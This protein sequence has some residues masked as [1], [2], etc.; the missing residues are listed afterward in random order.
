MTDRSVTSLWFR[1]GRLC[2]APEGASS[3]S[4]IGTGPWD[5]D[6]EKAAK[7]VEKA[8][9]AE[10]KKRKREEKEEEEEGEEEEEL[11]DSHYEDWCRKVLGNT[12]EKMDDEL[13]EAYEAKGNVGIAKVL[14]KRYKQ[15]HD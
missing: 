13:K 15:E 7:A 1:N 14:A 10:A 11:P 9:K 2:T 6:A 12:G 3:S 4:R 8:E 5:V